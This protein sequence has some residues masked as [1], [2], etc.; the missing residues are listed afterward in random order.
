MASLNLDD[1]D[2]DKLRA[3][4]KRWLAESDGI[5]QTYIPDAAVAAVEAAH[6]KGCDAYEA[7]F[8]AAFKAKY[9]ALR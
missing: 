1:L 6:E 4:L 2:F 8:R 9:D 7:A 3:R 5:R